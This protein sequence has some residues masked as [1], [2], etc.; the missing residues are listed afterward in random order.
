MDDLAI[1]NQLLDSIK[2]NK[3]IRLNKMNKFMCY[4]NINKFEKT[5]EINE[6]LETPQE[7][8]MKYALSY[9]TALDLY[10]IYLNDRD[11]AFYL[12]KNIKFVKE[13][14]D[15]INLLRRNHITF[16]DDGYE[17]Y[18]KYVKKLVLEEHK[19]GNI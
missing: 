12:L 11:F 18:K 13:E 10:Y 3:T 16:M 19:Y 2:N 8:I 15:I 6:Y 4:Y 5:E 7:I 1:R 9:L 14:D 17:N